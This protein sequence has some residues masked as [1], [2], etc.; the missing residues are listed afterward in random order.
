MLKVAVVGCGGVAQVH[1]QSIAALEGAELIA[2]ADILPERA[3]AYAARFGGRAYSSLDQ[4]LARE[5]PEVLHICTPHFLHVPMAILAHRH[6]VH[7]LMEKPPA[8]TRAQFAEL[9]AAFAFGEGRLSICFQNRF[10]GAFLHLKRLA[11]EERYGRVLGARAFVTWKREAPY[12]LESGWRGSL[13]TEGGGALINQSIHTLDL[14]AQ[15]L[16]RPLGVE[17]SCANRHLKGVIEVEDTVEATIDFG[18]KKALFYATTAYCE[19]SPVLLELSFEKGSAR[20][21]GNGVTERPAGAAAIFTDYDETALGKAY[22]GSGHQACI[23]EFYRCI[24]SG[25]AFVNDLDSVRATFSL[26]MGVYESAR[27][28]RPVSLT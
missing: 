23:A 3:E 24:K 10:I 11:E 27:E 22:W 15:L 2:C 16:G 21:E 14:L 1:G 17:A 25:D 5:K 9:E 13:A 4:L 19:D 18:E 8:I 28:G 12:Y 6:G 26:M 7:V 20:M